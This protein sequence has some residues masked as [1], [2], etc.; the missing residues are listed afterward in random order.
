MSA[1]EKLTRGVAW[2]NLDVLV[3]DMPPGTGDA[4]LSISQRLQLSGNQIWKTKE[5][6]LRNDSAI[7][8]IRIFFL[9]QYFQ[10][11]EKDDANKLI[12]LD[13]SRINI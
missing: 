7:Y 6:M 5:E 4:Q 1:L 2:G 13:I 9:Y 11:E 8:F 3:V 12:I 10:I